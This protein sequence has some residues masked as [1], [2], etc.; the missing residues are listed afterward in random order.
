MLRKPG[1]QNNPVVETIALNDLRYNMYG[2]ARY[3]APAVVGNFGS[4]VGGAIAGSLA[5][6]GSTIASATAAHPHRPAAKKGDA[7]A[8]GRSIEVWRGTKSDQVKVGEH[9]R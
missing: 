6:S 1:E 4:G 7:P 3:P 9:G 2:G 8:N 5:R